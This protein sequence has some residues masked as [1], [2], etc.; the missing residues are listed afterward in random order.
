MPLFAK[1]VPRVVE[2]VPFVAHGKERPILDTL[3]GSGV[4]DIVAVVIEGTGNGHGRGLSQWGAYGYAVDH[5][6]DWRQIL[7]HYYG[8]TR[9][10]T[11]TGGSRIEVRL[12]AGDGAT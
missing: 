8:G 5:G 7:E 12:L 1:N 11:I 2:G 6:W 3:L 10:G 9:A 4:G